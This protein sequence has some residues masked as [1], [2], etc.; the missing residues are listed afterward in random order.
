MQA[1]TD[2]ATTLLGASPAMAD[3][4]TQIARVARTPLPVLVEGETGTGKE[5]VAQALHGASGRRG[6]FV[7]VNVS[8]I[9]DT[10]FEAEMFGFQRG[11]F[12]GALKGSDGLS[13]RAD[14]GT[15]LLDEIGSLALPLQPKLLRVLETG[16]VTS[17]G[18]SAEVPVDVRVVAACN[19]GLSASV[20]AGRFRADL[21]QRLTGFRISLPPLRARLEDLPVLSKSFL[22]AAVPLVGGGCGSITAC[23]LK[24]LTRHAWPGNVRELK[25]VIARAL[26]LSPAG[27][28]DEAVVDDAL[29]MSGEIGLTLDVRSL[30]RDEEALRRALDQTEWNIYATAQLLMVTPKTVYQRI[31]RYGLVI[32]R[33]WQRRTRSGADSV[34][35]L[36]DSDNA[37]GAGGFTVNSP[38]LG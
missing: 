24:A 35:P 23:G 15:L 5:L 14:R 19:T 12:T 27:V 34:M 13:R 9:P 16:C 36:L 8:A 17:L 22:A 6:A 30:D 29:A 26:V 4:R 37:G 7:A 20:S 10:M 25:H 38:A 1:I 28:I 2:M 11:A 3:V 18:A 31:R 32:P 21:W 33:K